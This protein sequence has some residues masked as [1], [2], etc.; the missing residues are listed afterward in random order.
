MTSRTAGST[1]ELGRSRRRDQHHPDA[2]RP[3]QRHAPHAFD[4]RHDEHHHRSG[5][6]QARGSFK[7]EVGNDG[8]LKGT[9]VLST[10]LLNDTFAMTVG[11]VAKTGDGYV[12]GTWTDGYGYYIGT[13]WKVNETNR[14]ELFAIGAPQRHGQR[15]FASNIA[16]YDADY[17][18]SL[19]YSQ[20]DIT[21]ALNVGAQNAGNAFNPNYALSARPTP[22][23]SISG[24]HPY[25]PRRRLP[26]R[27]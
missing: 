11:L 20:A 12:R 21:A 13:S 19:G 2:A 23:S 1:V 5:G 17:A 14:L 9:A 8:F 27:A 15:T 6:Q 7:V 10:G 4:R 24:Q 3:Q 18:R 25:P 16:A 22:A 26:Q